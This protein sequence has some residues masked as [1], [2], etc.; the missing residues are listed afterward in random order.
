L[1][2]LI[3]DAGVDIML[4]TSP[5]AWAKLSLRKKVHGGPGVDFNVRGARV[6]LTY[7][8]SPATVGSS[9]AL[10]RDQQNARVGALYASLLRRP[11]TAAELT[12]ARELLDLG[13]TDAQL[14][15]FLSQV[16]E[17]E[18]MGEKVEDIYELL[19]DR[20][21]TDAEKSFWAKE[22]ADDRPELQARSYIQLIT[23]TFADI[24]G[25]TP[26]F[27]ELEVYAGLLDDGI[28]L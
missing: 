17:Q 7:D 15:A 16:H 13:Y 24:Y 5:S 6:R 3:P 26:T 27:L 14:L 21:P 19:Y 20:A 9:F 22:L 1:R 10:H 12:G 23:D 25:R 2:A 11:A 4:F 8:Y 28:P 18:A